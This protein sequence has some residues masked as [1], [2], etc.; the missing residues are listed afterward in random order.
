MGSQGRAEVLPRMTQNEM[1]TVAF[2]LGGTL[3]FRVDEPYGYSLITLT[4]QGFTVTARGDDMAYNLPNDKEIKVQVAYVDA[5]GNPA[6]VDGDVT[7][8]TSDS[9]IATVNVDDQDSTICTV[10]PAQQIGQAQISAK[11]DADIGQ[12]VREIITTMDVTIVAGEAIAGTIT[13]V[14]EPTPI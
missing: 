5:K 3:D 13:P 8:E 14:G 2:T 9:N 4:Y 1:T 10:T 12:G 6:V 11:A 7:W